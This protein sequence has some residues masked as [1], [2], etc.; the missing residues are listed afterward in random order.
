MGK[1]DIRGMN[2]N[3]DSHISIDDI[4]KTKEGSIVSR[5]PPSIFK[6]SCFFRLKINIPFA[7]ENLMAWESYGWAL[8]LPEDLKA[9]FFLIELLLNPLL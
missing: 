3:K 2:L 9:F 7:N 1:E 8:S 6:V 4:V 5:V